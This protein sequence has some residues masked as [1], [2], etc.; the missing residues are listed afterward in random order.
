MSRRGRF[1]TYE[2]SADENAPDVAVDSDDRLRAISS[3]GDG[4]RVDGAHPLTDSTALTLAHTPQEE[5]VEQTK[6]EIEDDD[7]RR[8]E[9]VSWDEGTATR[10][11]A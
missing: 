1:G 4:S 8:H 7:A 2:R 3:D 5:F 9:L 11:F 10:R 6:A